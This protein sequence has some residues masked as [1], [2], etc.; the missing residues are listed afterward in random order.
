[1][2]EEVFSS[3]QSA[4]KYTC[5]VRG[6]NTFTRESYEAF[7]LEQV[8]Q[9]AREGQIN[10]FKISTPEGRNIGSSDFPF[11]GNLIV[12]EYNAAKVE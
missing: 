3:E 4:I 2:S 6:R 7:T 8:K 12:R 10:N 9:W 11:K 1:M 5:E